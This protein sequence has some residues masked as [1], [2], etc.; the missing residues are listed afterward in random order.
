MDP[1][2]DQGLAHRQDSLQDPLHWVRLGTS[3]Q[4]HEDY[5]GG[6]MI[7]MLKT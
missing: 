1:I 6:R 2:G 3:S 4:C 7:S 5:S